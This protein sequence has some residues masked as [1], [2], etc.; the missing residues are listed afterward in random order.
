M[1][2]GRPYSVV[3]VYEPR[4]RPHCHCHTPLGMRWNAGI[5]SWPAQLLK[6]RNQIS[7]WKNLPR[8]GDKGAAQTDPQSTWWPS[9]FRFKLGSTDGVQGLLPGKIVRL[10]RVDVIGVGKASPLGVRGEAK[11][12]DASL[13]LSSDGICGV[14]NFGSLDCRSLLWK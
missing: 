5:R 12:E 10:A 7:W 9:R 11:K 3:F 2:A 4:R 14:D 6:I 13:L 8:W 1:R